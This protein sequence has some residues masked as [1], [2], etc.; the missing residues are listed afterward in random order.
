MKSIRHFWSSKSHALAGIAYA[1]RH[2]QNFR[3]QL[4]LGGVVVLLM[5]GFKV[6]AYEAVL[7]LLTMSLVLV[8]EL[9]NTAVESLSDIMK[10]RLN[11]QVRIA[12][13]VASGMVLL[14]SM[15][16][17]II[18]LI[19]FYPYVVRLLNSGVI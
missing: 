6:S 4:V 16:S 3:S 14:G 11:D 19:I 2:E 15:V 10:P 1:I 9:F 17:F 18:G 13:D 12:K 8:L 7:L 5:I